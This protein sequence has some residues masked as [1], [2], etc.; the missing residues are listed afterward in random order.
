MVAIAEGRRQSGVAQTL[1]LT[2]LTGRTTPQLSSAELGSE[3]L[4][5]T[6]L[7]ESAGHGRLSCGTP[8]PGFA[9]PS[10]TSAPSSGM[11]SAAGARCG[12]S[13]RKLPPGDPPQQLPA[14][15]R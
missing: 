2:A 12:A 10:A 14:P 13:G 9:D 15:R 3:S 5:D 1:H 8:L 7:V 6:G 11:A 4:I